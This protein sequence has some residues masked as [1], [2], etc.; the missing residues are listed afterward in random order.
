MELGEC[1]VRD[2]V[3]LLSKAVSYHVSDV[4]EAR[5][6]INF[7]RCVMVRRRIPAEPAEPFMPCLEEFEP[8]YNP[9][10]ESGSF[11]VQ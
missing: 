4:N 8:A 10:W 3:V 6:R 2:N 1:Q 11:E 7:F 5:Q 9:P